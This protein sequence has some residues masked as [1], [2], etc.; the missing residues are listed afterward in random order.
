MGPIAIA[1]IRAASTTNFDSLR[2]VKREVAF[3]N[4]Q[5]ALIG[6]NQQW[7]VNDSLYYLM[8]RYTTENS[9]KTDI[10]TEINCMGIV[11]VTEPN[12]YQ[13]AGCKL[14]GPWDMWK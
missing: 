11:T 8:T 14:M 6:S 13:H 2:L 3:P 7:R 9:E 1:S 10:M 12:I 5:R 4:P